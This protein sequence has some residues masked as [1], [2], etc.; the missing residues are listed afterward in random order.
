ML[1]YIQFITITTKY[2]WTIL[3]STPQS[4]AR[5]ETATFWTSAKPREDVWR[6]QLKF[7]PMT[8]IKMNYKAIAER[9]SRQAIQKPLKSMK[10]KIILK[11][12]TSN[13]RNFKTHIKSLGRVTFKEKQHWSSTNGRY[14]LLD[15][16]KLL[17]AHPVKTL[18]LWR[19]ELDQL[20][21]LHKFR[22]SNVISHPQQPHLHSKGSLV[23][24]S[25]QI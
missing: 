16:D 6:R 25:N 24:E 17:C 12:R 21:Q 11:L 22:Q 4:N 20:S 5:R 2:K 8:M 1:W 3:K 19:W 9:F 23:W 7:L 10:L 14:I 18:L 15:L 13:Q